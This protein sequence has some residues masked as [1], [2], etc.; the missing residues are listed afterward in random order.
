MISDEERIEVAAKLRERK[1]DFF[2][3]RSF[4]PQ[5]LILYQS[6]YLKAIDECLPDGD[7]CFD[8]LAELIDRPT[9]KN[10]ATKPADELLCSRCG[11]HVDI[12]Y[13]ENVDDYYASYCPNCGAKVVDE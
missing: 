5:D 4:F 1:E 3:V 2:G 12:A 7:C 9:C 6:L 10:I 11:E 13:M 8:M